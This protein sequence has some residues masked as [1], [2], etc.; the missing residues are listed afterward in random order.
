[1]KQGKQPLYIAYPR[2]AMA[3]SDSPWAS[4]TTAEQGRRGH[5]I[6]TELQTYIL[7]DPDARA[8]HRT[9]RRP[10][11]GVALS[12]DKADPAVFNWPGAS[13]RRQGTGRHLPG[14]AGDGGLADT[15]TAVPP[16]RPDLL[17]PRRLRL[18]D[19]KR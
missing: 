2:G 3:I 8:D 10:A 18:D 15:T 6:F 16:C 17:L 5:Q 14:G 12:L 1:M 13:A 7:S 4:R 11:G 19:R 9:G